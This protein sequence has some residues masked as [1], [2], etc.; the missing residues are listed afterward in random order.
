MRC[1]AIARSCP[2][3]LESRKYSPSQDV[4]GS[5]GRQRLHRS[6]RVWWSIRNRQV[7]E[8]RVNTQR[9]LPGSGCVETL[10]KLAV[11]ELTVSQ[12][13]GKGF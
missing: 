5:I 7:L 8:R 13:K 9:N 12:Q 2:T 6:S 4:G 10:W 1:V 3:V 11:R